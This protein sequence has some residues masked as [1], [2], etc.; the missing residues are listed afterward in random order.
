[1]HGRPC[2]L[3][4]PPH[5]LKSPLYTTAFVSGGD[6]QYY[7]DAST[8][9]PP[10]HSVAMCWIYSFLIV[11]FT[12]LLHYGGAVRVSIFRSISTSLCAWSYDVAFWLCLSCM[13]RA[14]FI[15][16]WLHTLSCLSCWFHSLV[17]D[18][19]I[20]IGLLLPLFRP[21]HLLHLAS[22]LTFSI[23]KEVTVSDRWLDLIVLPIYHL[24]GTWYSCSVIIH[25][26]SIH[27]VGSGEQMEHRLICCWRLLFLVTR[28]DSLTSCSGT[29][30]SLHWISGVPLP[31]LLMHC[32]LSLPRHLLMTDVSFSLNARLSLRYLDISHF[33]VT[34]FLLFHLWHSLVRA[35]F[36]WSVRYLSLRYCGT[37]SAPFCGTMGILVEAK[38]QRCSWSL[39]ILFILFPAFI[40]RRHSLF[41]SFIFYK[42]FISFLFVI[43]TS[44]HFISFCFIC[45]CDSL[46]SLI[47]ILLCLI[48]CISRGDRQA[49]LITSL[50]SLV[51]SFCYGMHLFVRR[52]SC[53]VSHSFF[54]VAFFTFPHFLSGEVCWLLCWPFV[55]LHVHLITGDLCPHILLTH[56]PWAFTSASVVA[57]LRPSL[58]VTP[59]STSLSYT[60]PLNISSFLALIRW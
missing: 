12:H 2:S 21:I 18:W 15:V 11:L 23:S 37:I 1:V 50:C 52:T 49:R 30:L 10:V 31:H 25:W 34:V 9:W 20:T 48:C 6:V 3:V 35:I 7:L 56:S 51:I 60:L 59:H 54:F 55:L 45:C 27:L 4:M 38:Q 36:I 33:F 58:F 44:F 57:W 28:C 17:F 39:F 47:V 46:V 41:C 29:F 42:S 53:I 8:F 24:C 16:V 26:Y 40:C 32:C 5:F 13:L 43:L 14:T 19:Y 22:T